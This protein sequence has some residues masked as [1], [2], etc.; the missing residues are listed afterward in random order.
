MAGYTFKQFVER[1][2]FPGPVTWGHAPEIPDKLWR[3][4]LRTSIWHNSA[5]LHHPH[6]LAW[7]WGLSCLSQMWLLW[8]GQGYDA[9]HSRVPSEATQ[10]ATKREAEKAAPG[11]STHQAFQMAKATRSEMPGR[12]NHVAFLMGL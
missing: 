9:A 12:L 6:H 4:P 7:Y 3:A 11:Q 1:G 8:I 5:E 10:P 2:Y